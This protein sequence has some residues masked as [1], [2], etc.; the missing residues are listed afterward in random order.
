MIP[1]TAS[2]VIPARPMIIAVAPAPT[3]AAVA[4]NLDRFGAL[5]TVDNGILAEGI[6]DRIRALLDGRSH[7]GRASENLRIRAC[8][9]LPLAALSELRTTAAICRC[10]LKCSLD[11][12][13]LTVTPGSHPIVGSGWTCRRWEV[14]VERGR[15]GCRV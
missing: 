10:L 1:T 6:P 12:A 7:R 2:L 5:C 13:K 15:S 11:A 14:S 8:Q 3:I 4:Y 9:A